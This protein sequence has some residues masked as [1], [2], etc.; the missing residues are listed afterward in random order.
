MFATCN[1]RSWGHACLFCLVFVVLG[2]GRKLCTGIWTRGN[3]GASSDGVTC[4]AIYRGFLLGISFLLGDFK[5]KMITNQ[6]VTSFLLVPLQMT[7]LATRFQFLLCLLLL[8]LLLFVCVFPFWTT[9]KSRR[10]QKG[11]KIVPRSHSPLIFFLIIWNMLEG[12]G[13]I[14]SIWLRTWL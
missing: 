14:K 12:N 9:L 2:D 5:V 7:V 8:L 11:F 1:R 13:D 6:F 3:I 4:S 10:I